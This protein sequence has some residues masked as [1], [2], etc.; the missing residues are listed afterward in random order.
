MFGPMYEPVVSSNASD[1]FTYFNT[2]GSDILN[3]CSANGA[4]DA[5]EIFESTVALGERPCYKVISVFTGS[6]LDVHLGVGSSEDF[7][8]HD[9]VDDHNTCIA[10]LGK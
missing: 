4:R 9:F 5:N 3:R 6:D 7:F 1:F 8:T 2:I 10:W